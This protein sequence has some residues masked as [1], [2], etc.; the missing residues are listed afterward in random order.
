MAE[1]TDVTAAVRYLR[2]VH[3]GQSST[4]FALGVS[5]GATAVLEAAQQD[6]R[7]DAVVIDSAFPSRAE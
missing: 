4:L 7:I 3:P 2:Q 6:G 1:S 5:E